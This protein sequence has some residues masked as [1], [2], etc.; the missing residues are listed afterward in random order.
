MLLLNKSATVLTTVKRM[1]FA[2]LADA[3]RGSSPGLDRPLL[4]SVARS[5]SAIGRRRDG[6]QA[7]P[8][9]TENRN[10][11]FVVQGRARC[12]G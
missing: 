6:E 1:G 3:A 7:F 2:M 4:T 11:R 8:L 9:Q 10:L 5:G 12:I